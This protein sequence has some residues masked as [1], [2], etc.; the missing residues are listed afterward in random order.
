MTHE[1]VVT[2]VETQYDSSG[3]A[4]CKQ[5]VKPSARHDYSTFSSRTE[6]GIAG[7]PCRLVVPCPV[8]DVVYGFGRLDGVS[9]CCLEGGIEWLASNW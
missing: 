6:G 9:R 8:S 4:A 3:F 5:W 7:G 2:G 1:R